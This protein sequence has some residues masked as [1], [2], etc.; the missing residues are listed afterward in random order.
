MHSNRFRFTLGRLM[1]IIG[2]IAGVLATETYIARRAVEM[3]SEDYD[4]TPRYIQGE[5]VLAGIALHVLLVW[6]VLFGFAIWYVILR[7]LRWRR[8]ASK[9]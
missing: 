6:L 9:N 1:G 5:A 8:L 4:G 3:V 7:F 2:I